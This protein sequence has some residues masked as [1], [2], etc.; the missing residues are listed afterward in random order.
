MHLRSLLLLLLLLSS[1]QAVNNDATEVALTHGS[2]P[3]PESAEQRLPEPRAHRRQRNERRRAG[4]RRSKPSR[5]QGAALHQV[6][7]RRPL[8]QHQ[9][10]QG[11]G[12]CWRVSPRP[13]AS[14]LDWQH[15]QQ[16]VLESP[17]Q[18]PR[19]A[20]RQRQ[21][22]NP[23]HPATVSGRQHENVQNHRGHLLQVQEVLEA[24]QRIGEQV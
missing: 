1:G 9:T 18:Q 2:A 15:L 4:R 14:K 3:A 16:E 8:H 20:V 19:L 24:A 23:A 12:V 13:D 21:D 11:T 6:H 10:H 7:L 5:M 22:P 17:Q